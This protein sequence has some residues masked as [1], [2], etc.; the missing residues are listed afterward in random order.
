MEQKMNRIAIIISCVVCF[1]GI[2]GKIDAQTTPEEYQDSILSFNVAQ[3]VRI[4]RIRQ[5][6]DSIK[7]L[8]G[9]PNVLCQL[10]QSIDSLRMVK[11]GLVE[12][13][14]MLLD[15][16]V[17]SDSQ[18]RGLSDYNRFIMD[19]ICRFANSQLSLK[20]NEVNVNK[21]IHYLDIVNDDDLRKKTT[22]LP[23]LLK[24]YQ[25]D[26]VDFMNVINEAQNDNRR[27]Y[28]LFEEEYRNTYISRLKNL[29]YYEDYY[30]KN[31][32]KWKV[33]RIYYLSEEIDKA[34]ALLN[35]HNFDTNSPFTVDFSYL[36]L[37]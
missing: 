17:E 29:D 3:R 25:S 1:I 21:A 24:R 11:R 23:E 8:E 15:D 19:C 36:L 18:N 28:R 30:V 4:D 32:N 37:D 22:S 13:E 7:G 12:Q 2:C 6:D 27:T 26:Y 10:E 33:W 5:L 31:G 9:L 35:K 20:Y 14:A 34:I 16:N